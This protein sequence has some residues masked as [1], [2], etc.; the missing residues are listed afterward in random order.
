VAKG[1][2]EPAALQAERAGER[3]AAQAC[4]EAAATSAAR[5]TIVRSEAAS[6]AACHLICQLLCRIQGSSWCISASARAST[7]VLWGLKPCRPLSPMVTSRNSST[8][9]VSD[10]SGLREQQRQ[11]H[12]V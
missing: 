7:M 10:K 12:L 11:M 8:C 6:P 1:A 5:L 3:D 4:T 9:T 2:K